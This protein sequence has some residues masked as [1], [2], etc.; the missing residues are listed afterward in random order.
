[1]ADRQISGDQLRE[2]LDLIGDA[3]SVELKLTLAETARAEVP[4]RRSVWT[5]STRRSGRCSSSIPRTW[6]WTRRGWWFEP[7]VGRARWATRSSSSVPSCL[8]ELPDELRRST[9]ASTLEV[10][11]MPG[12][13]VVPPRR[14]RGR[15]TTARSGE[16]LRANGASAGKLF[17]KE[18]RAFFATHAPKGPQP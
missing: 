11:A 4:R 6:P 1:M 3:D 18:Q 9:P 7:G 10:D 14:S 13:F 17:S 5:R 8:P 12:G 15:R 16:P 2:L